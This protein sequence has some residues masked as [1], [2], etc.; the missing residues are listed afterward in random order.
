[1]H[2]GLLS[3]ISASS[4]QLEE[5]PGDCKK[6]NI[7]H[8]SQKGKKENPGNYKPVSL[9]SVPERV[10]EHI[11][12]E[13]IFKYIMDKMIRSCQS[14]YRCRKSCLTNLVACDEMTG[15]ADEGRAVHVILT[16]A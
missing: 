7:T 5:I 4:W 8:V 3:I 2:A 12:M 15:F 1:M 13:A 11:F 10:T 6:A 14:G 16:L 9:T